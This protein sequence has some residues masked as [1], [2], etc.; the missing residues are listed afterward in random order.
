MLRP[1]CCSTIEH[2]SS[3]EHSTAGFSSA[4]ASIRLQVRSDKKSTAWM[5]VW[6]ARDDYKI[7]NRH[8]PE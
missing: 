2:P 1:G 8:Q 7:K 4:R 5:C 3:T 6:R